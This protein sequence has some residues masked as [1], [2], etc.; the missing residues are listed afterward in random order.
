MEGYIIARNDRNKDGGEVLLAVSNKYKQ[1][2]T[3]VDRF[4]GTEESL[5]I[6]VGTKTIYRIGVVY[7]PK[8][9]MEKTK[10]LKETYNQIEEQ[11]NKAGEQQQKIVI[12][13]DFNCKVG[14]IIDGNK[15]EVTKGGKMLIEMKQ[16]GNGNSKQP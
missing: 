16:E 5:W 4:N 7:I 14:R 11:V 2:V 10:V 12:M 15:D 9:D 8:G 6:T 3:E 1:I 13:G